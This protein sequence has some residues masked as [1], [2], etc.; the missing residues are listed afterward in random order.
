MP[1]HAEASSGMRRFSPSLLV[2][3][4]LAAV[5]APNV[6]VTFEDIAARA[7]ITFVLRDSATPAKHQIETMVG[8]VA[9]FDYN[10]D[11]KPDIYFVN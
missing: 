3:L 6:R 7:G 5:A 9:I 1:Y 10:N 8:G 4:V 2:L 11:G